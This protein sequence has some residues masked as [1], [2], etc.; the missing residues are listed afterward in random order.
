M[1]Y[2]S[3][4]NY[5]KCDEWGLN[6]VQGA[7]FDLLNESS[8]WAKTHIIGNDVYYWVSRN[9]VLDELPVVFKR[10]DTV[11]RNLKVLAEKELIIYTKEGVKDLIMLTEKGKTWNSKINSEKNPSKSKDLENTEK[12][13]SK[14]GNKSENTHENT[15]I[16]PTDKDT[17]YKSTNDEVEHDNNAEKVKDSNA[18]FIV[19]WQ[20]P[21][22]ET[23]EAKLLMAGT[24]MQMTDGQYQLYVD[25]FK[26]HFEDRAKDGHPL[27]SDGKCQAKLRDWLQRERE[28]HNKNMNAG[29]ETANRPHSNRSDSFSQ[30]SGPKLTRQQQIEKN[31]QAMQQAGLPV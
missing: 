11:Y 4:I 10:A 19:N 14:L 15:D 23:M 22:R 28:G 9:K 20:P 29:G 17:S 2:H 27:K 16:N 26:A 18:E 1:R 5:V 3:R 30:S 24:P 21:T 12:N 31:K 25:D 8:S 7:L 13:P 6:V